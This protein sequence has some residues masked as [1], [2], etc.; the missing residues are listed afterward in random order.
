MSTERNIKRVQVTFTNEQWEMIESMKGEMG[1]TT[2][3]I[4]RN[5]VLAWLAEKSLISERI[6][7]K[8]GGI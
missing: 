4:V 2:A 6:K 5:I 8:K 3:E 1:N 7:K